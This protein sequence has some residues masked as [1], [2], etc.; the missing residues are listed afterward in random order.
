M[1]SKIVRDDYGRLYYLQESQDIEDP[2][3]YWGYWEPCNS[4]TETEGLSAKD[5]VKKEKS[6]VVDRVL[7]E[8]NIYI[9]N[10]NSLVLE[11]ENNFEKVKVYKL[12]SD[13]AD[14]ITFLVIE[15]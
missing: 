10:L 6:N 8:T 13:V 12:I 7:Q 15:D 14:S 9:K 2:N 1:E 3:F 4:T 11:T 5:P